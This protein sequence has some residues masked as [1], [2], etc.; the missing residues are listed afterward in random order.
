VWH[1][2]QAVLPELI[3]AITPESL[4][5]WHVAQVRPR[6]ACSTVR[7][8]SWQLAQFAANADCVVVCPAT[9]GVVACSVWH[10]E[11]A[12]LPEPMASRTFTSVDEWHVAQV[13]PRAACSTVRSPLWQDEQFAAN[14]GC[15]VVCG[16]V[17]PCSVWHAEHAV[18]PEP[19]AA[20][21]PGLVDEWHVA[22]VSPRAAC[23]TVSSALWHDEQFAANDACVVVWPAT[24]GVIEWTVWHAEQAVLPELIAA[25]TPESELAWHVRQV[26]PRAA[27]STVRSPLWHDE[28]FAAND[29]C[30]V[31]WPATGGVIEWTT[32]HA[33]HAVLPDPIASVTPESVDP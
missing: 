31:V 13:R 6:A 9:G 7:L 15:V 21:T 3:A 4:E 12:V 17:A 24:G 25:R 30:V 19:I 29:A 11:Q 5:E 22:H 18:F 10:A 2:E 1:A 14:A 20:I 16:G 27:C 32:W 26:S 28:Q 8:A 33:P 23:S